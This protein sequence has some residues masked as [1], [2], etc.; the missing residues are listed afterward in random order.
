MGMCLRDG[1]SLDKSLNLGVSFKHF[2]DPR[3]QELFAKLTQLIQNDHVDDLLIKAGAAMPQHAAYL[4]SLHSDAPIGDDVAYYAEEVLEAAF[5]RAAAVQLARLSGLASSR[6][7]FAGSSL[8]RLMTEELLTAENGPGP[9]IGPRELP[10]VV[11]DVLLEIEENVA[12]AGTGQLPGLRTGFAKLDRAIMGLRPGWAYVI[13]ART[14]VGK[15]TLALQI[16]LNVAFAQ[17]QALYLTFEQ[18]DTDLM[19]KAI[20]HLGRVQMRSMFEGEVTPDDCDRITKATR[21]IC[22]TG[23]KI[24]NSSDAELQNVELLCGRLKRQGKLDLVVIDYIQLMTIPG[25]RH[26]NRTEEVSKISRRL[27]GLARKLKVPI[28]VLAQIN[29]RGTETDEP[30]IQHLKDSGSIEQDADVIIL[31]HRDDD[32][33]VL[34]VAKNRRGQPT[35]IA[36]NENLAFS[37]FSEVE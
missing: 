37:A 15:T 19:V 11:N 10:V 2:T 18:L 34:K 8:R 29:R 13:G 36:L 17:K 7:P 35:R 1:L 22:D 4:A 12:I 27:K 21:D 9:Q 23:L 33:A 5:H 24:D 14:G 20:G 3:N 32:G 28:I 26:V 6:Q 16:A 25:E 31:L 30:E